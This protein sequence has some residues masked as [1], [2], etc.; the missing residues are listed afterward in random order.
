MVLF[1]SIDG[2]GSYIPLN[3]ES[4]SE[5]ISTESRP[6]DKFDPVLYEYCMEVYAPLKQSCSEVPT[7]GGRYGPITCAARTCAH[8]A[9]IHERARGRY[10]FL[11]GINPIDAQVNGTYSPYASTEYYH[12]KY[13]TVDPTSVDDKKKFFL[14]G[15]IYALKATG[16]LSSFLS[17]VQRATSG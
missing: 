11:A 14:L 16:K 1:D 17:S 6:G 12:L 15:F 2:G 5:C 9:P 10:E 3:V 13:D 8:W 7:D 4:I